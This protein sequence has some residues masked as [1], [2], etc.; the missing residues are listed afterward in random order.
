MSE[1][2]QKE[3]IMTKVNRARFHI[4]LKWETKNPVS[5]H[6]GVPKPHIGESQSHLNLL[7][8]SQSQSAFPDSVYL[9]ASVIFQNSHHEK[10][11]CHQLVKY[12]EGRGL[13]L[14]QVK[15]EMLRPAYE[16]AFNTLRYQELL[17]DVITDGGAFISHPIPDDQMSLF[18]VMLYDFQDRK[19]FPK[20]HK[21]EDSIQEVRD[22]QSYLIRCKTKLEASL[23]RYRIKHDLSSLDCILPE[24]V[25]VKQE[26]SNRLPL[27][28]WVNALRSSLDE[29]QSVLMRAGL[30]Q[31]NSVRQLEGQTFCQDPD[32]ED[33]L[34]FP[35]RT[36]ARLDSTT[37]LHNRKLIIQDKSC[38]LASNMAVSLLPRDGDILI[39]GRFS[40]LTI[41]HMA[42]LIKE[43]HKVNGD[44]SRVLACVS[45]LTDAQREAMQQVIVH[46]NC[47]NVKLINEGFQSLTSG[48]KRL[49]K[50]RLILLTP[51]C[52]LSAV[53][54]PLEFILQENRDTVL[55]QDLSQG[56][57]AQSRL[58]ALI[59][60]QRED[61]DHALKFPKV[62][63]VVYATCSSYPQEN[64]EVVTRAIQQA[65]VMAQ[66]EWRLGKNEL[67][68]ALNCS[69]DHAGGR[70]RKK[71][72]NCFFRVKPSELSNGCF[73]AILIRDVKIKSSQPELVAK[74][75]SQPVQAKVSANRKS[76][77]VKSNQPTRKKQR[78]QAIRPTKVTF[79]KKTEHQVSEKKRHLPRGTPPKPRL[80][81]SQNSI[82]DS[83]CTLENSN[84][85]TLNPKRNPKIHIIT[86]G[87]NTVTSTSKLR[88]VPPLITPTKFAARLQ[89][90]QQ[91]VLKPAVIVLPPQHLPQSPLPQLPMWRT[92]A[93]TLPS[94]R[95]LGSFP[96]DTL[97]KHKMRFYV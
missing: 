1:Q 20:D 71:E 41:S 14:P 44:K 53:S 30:S 19:F 94:S 86:P 7:N 10:P 43:K 48:D 90:V 62:L 34:V 16:L 92:P 5:Q 18:A 91:L 55:L 77:R 11:A 57:V 26:R 50:V 64:E 47:K 13:P 76:E 65:N 95:A 70:E 38:S 25:K 60:Q 52:S 56:C 51:N 42:S 54:N 66:Q 68:Q 22:V 29:V 32:C 17:E 45:G 82:L 84:S 35:A 75:G 46:M 80:E 88:P 21:I 63:A 93:P 9:L 78:G 40:G 36:K 23:A 58:E 39:V 85:G 59:A 73:L 28:A 37:L 96:K 79:A 15:D 67:S 27:Y 12:G 89:K 8:T 83:H 49:A 6:A 3:T 74:E 69:P 31:M 2:T 4:A 97:L 72:S 33:L 87:F 81:T 24:S 61:I